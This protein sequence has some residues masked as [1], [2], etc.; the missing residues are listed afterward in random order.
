MSKNIYKVVIDLL[1]ML[2][3]LAAIITGFKLHKEVWHLHVYDDSFLWGTHETIGLTLLVLVAAHCIQ[4]SFWFRNYSKI[5]VEKKRVTAILLTIGIITA[6]TGILL[7]CG[8]HSEFI[9]H[10]HYAGA[11]LFTAITIGHLAKRWK[12]LKAIS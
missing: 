3:L 4:H 8:S 6:V 12:I 9:S 7:M 10:T 1:S 2:A 5:K 11:I